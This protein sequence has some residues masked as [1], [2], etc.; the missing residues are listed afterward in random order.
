MTAKNKTT[1]TAKSSTALRGHVILMRL[2]PTQR[3]TSQLL[4]LAGF[5][6]FCMSDAAAQAPH[7]A[8]FEVASVKPA[9]PDADPNYGYWSY[10]GIGRFKANHL[11]LAHLIALAYDIDVSQIDNAPIWLDVNLYDIEATPEAGVHLSREELRPRL[12]ALLQQR[13]HLVAHPGT[14]LIQ[15]YALV[16]AKGG[17]HLTPTKGA[18]FPGFSVDTSRGQMRGKDW[19]MPQLA[20][21]LTHAAGFPVV[22]Q[23][24]LAGSYDI[25]FSYEPNPVADSALPPLDVALKQATGLLLKSQKVTVETLVI[26]SVDKVPSAN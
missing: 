7:L 14:H 10:P 19:S 25:A 21:F 6:F 12:Q 8:T 17:Q 20:R 15:G 16:I 5:I 26:D 4:F 24:G 9:P 13:F 1:A 3:F 18:L 2:S 22:D 11:S 23:T